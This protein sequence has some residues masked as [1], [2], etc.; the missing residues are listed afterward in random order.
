MRTDVLLLNDTRKLLPTT[1]SG[2]A[3]PIAPPKPP[4]VRL[5]PDIRSLSQAIVCGDEA[6]FDAFYELYSARLY[7][8]LLVVTSGDEETAREVQQVVMIKAAR[9]FKVFAG[10][11]ELWAWL[12]QVARNAFVDH[13]R[14]LARHS[15]QASLDAVTPCLNFEESRADEQLI[16]WL[17]QGLAELHPEDR[18]LIELVYS[19]GRAQKD[20]AAE[21]GKTVKSIESKLARLRQKLRKT[22]LQRIRHER[23]TH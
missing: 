2:D 17:E 20:L 8:L 23:K 15:G 11:A 1:D 10:D 16:E 22:V 9:K 4:L 19:Q 14:K 18:E 6:A 3:E 12:S 5:E 7:R 21:S 13:I